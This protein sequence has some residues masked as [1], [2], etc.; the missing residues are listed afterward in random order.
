MSTATQLDT[1]QQ[2][3]RFRTALDWV[4]DNADWLPPGWLISR[5]GELVWGRKSNRLAV[6]ES[7]AHRLGPAEGRASSSYWPREGSRPALS[8]QWGQP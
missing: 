2:A 6:L 7:V 5:E 4:D 8:I 3:N 1:R